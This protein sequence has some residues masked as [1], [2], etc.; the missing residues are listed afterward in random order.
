MSEACT[1]LVRVRLHLRTRMEKG[2]SDYSQLRTA[3]NFL[4]RVINQQQAA[5]EELRSCN[6]ELEAIL[7]EVLA[8][9][10]DLRKAYAEV[11][12]EEDV[13]RSP[14]ARIPRLAGELDLP[15]LKQDADRLLRKGGDT[16]RESAQLRLRSKRLRSALRGGAPRSKPHAWDL[17]L[18]KRE[19][20][21]LALIVEGKTSK[22][23]AA[24]LG[25]SFKTAVTHRS[26]IMAKLD[27]HEIASVVREAIRRGLV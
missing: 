11:R 26:S 4:L 6:R 1:T 21:V 3:K 13:T 18:S 5:T 14:A 7:E 9:R 23:I 15:R 10:P 16:I 2:I 12:L 20:Q 22:E 8:F 25:I 27:V 17:P 19:R 24:E